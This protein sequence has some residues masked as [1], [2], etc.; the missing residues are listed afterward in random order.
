MH[1][2]PALSN[3]ALLSPVPVQWG[4]FVCDG[5]SM[6][7]VIATLYVQCCYAG[8][9]IHESISSSWTNSSFEL[10]HFQFM[11]K[12]QFWAGNRASSTHPMTLYKHTLHVTGRRSASGSGSACLCAWWQSARRRGRSWGRW[13]DSPFFVLFLFNLKNTFS[14]RQ[15]IFVCLVAKCKETG[16]SRW[17]WVVFASSLLS[18]CTESPPVVHVH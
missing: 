8:S 2:Q 7:P 13:V 14:I 4:A 10:V 16:Q 1:Q 15:R 17:R 12:F 6:L 3:G 9:S 5:C 18:C 11:N